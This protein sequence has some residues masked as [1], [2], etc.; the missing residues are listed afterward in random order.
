[1][2][3]GLG[4]VLGTHH[5]E[6]NCIAMQVLEE[7]YPEGVRDFRRMLEKAG[8]EIPPGLTAGLPPQKLDKMIEVSLGMAPLWQNALGDDWKRQMPPERLRA[9]YQ[10]M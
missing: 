2:S 4:Y 3:Y 6:G 10:R 5:G 9:L 7:F 8:V 1:M